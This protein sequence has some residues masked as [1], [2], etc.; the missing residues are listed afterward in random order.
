MRI[1]FIILFWVNIVC[2]LHAEHHLG[3]EITAEFIETVGTA[4]KYLIRYDYYTDCGITTIPLDSQQFFIIPIANIDPLSNYD[5][6]ELDTYELIPELSYPC[7]ESPNEC[8]IIAR[9]S[10]EIVIE[11]SSDSYIIGRGTY[12]M[13]NINNI[14]GEFIGGLHILEITPELFQLKN[15]NPITEF[16]PPPF[17]C[18]NEPF[19]FSYNANDIDGDQIVYELAP[20]NS[21]I[22]E[23]LVQ[24]L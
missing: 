21:I 5:Y 1:F 8:A 7:L 2:S 12:W 16:L 23:P 3:G 14:D 13:E 22:G 4:N 9:Y 17:F 10:K 18:V 6:L 19:N 11:P 20:P 24:F 15:S